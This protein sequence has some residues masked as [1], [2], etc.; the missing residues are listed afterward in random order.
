[1]YR[2]GNGFTKKGHLTSLFLPDFDFEKPNLFYGDFRNDLWLFKKNKNYIEIFI[3]PE[4]KDY[5][6]MIFSMFYDGEFDTEIKSLRDKAN[7]Q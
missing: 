1:M 4:N 5:S 2:I 7:S 6:D 3:I